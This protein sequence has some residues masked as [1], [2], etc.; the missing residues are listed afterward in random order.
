MA[1]KDSPH[2]IGTLAA[3]FDEDGPAD[4]PGSPLDPNCVKVV[5]DH[6]GCALYFSRSPIPYP[7]DTNG[8]VDK[9]SRW[10]LHLGVYVFR[11][12]TLRTVTQEAGLTRGS[13]E[14]VESLEQLRWL[15]HGLSVAVVIVDHLFV[16]IDTP[17][18]YAAFVS[19]LAVGTRRVGADV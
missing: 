13:L 1:D 2:G 18:D 15:E 8:A 9:P 17:E 5:V 16:G 10:L 19:R 3:P 4:G 14:A 12:N 7:R 11:A 6:G